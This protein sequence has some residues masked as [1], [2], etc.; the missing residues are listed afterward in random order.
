MPLNEFSNNSNTH[1]STL[2]LQVPD[3]IL[4]AIISLLDSSESPS[5][6]PDF[7]AQSSW[8]TCS[9]VC[10]RWRNI[11]LPYLFR[12]VHLI[13]P[14]IAPISR[15]VFLETP[16]I[17]SLVRECW[18][19]K[20]TIE[21]VDELVRLLDSLTS[22]RCLRLDSV[23]IC[24]DDL[25]PRRPLRYASH[26]LETLIYHVQHPTP[27]FHSFVTFI[28]LLALFSEIGELRTNVITDDEVDD[29]NWP[30]EED[31]NVF[32]T[33]GSPN[34]STTS[35][36]SSIQALSPR[37]RKLACQ[38]Y[39]NDISGASHFI[40]LYLFK[41]GIARSLTHLAFNSTCAV[42]WEAFLGC[43]SAAHSTL[44]CLHIEIVIFTKDGAFTSQPISHHTTKHHPSVL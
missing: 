44:T 42:E 21:D 7:S 22:L 12:S 6:H 13:D 25:S 2:S 17:A 31:V 4:E 43:M 28:D 36:T 10:K 29:E 41:L 15:T 40:P 18:L 14:E 1:R 11:V 5:S 24:G 33:A 30:T 35:D 8:F 38:Y 32:A 3:E 9:L 19:E 23:T 27:L 34:T 39:S 20:V 16:V 26:K 37:I